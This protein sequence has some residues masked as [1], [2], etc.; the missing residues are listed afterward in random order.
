M[1]DR[2]LELLR[3][4]KHYVIQ[5]CHVPDRPAPVVEPSDLDFSDSSDMFQT[6]DIAITRT[7][8]RY[9]RYSYDGP[10]GPRARTVRVCAKLC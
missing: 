2:L 10:S 1:A 6:V 4:T 5:V 9:S 3:L 7:T 8:D